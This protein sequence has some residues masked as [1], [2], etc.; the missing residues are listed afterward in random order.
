MTR[1]PV[2]YAVLNL[3]TEKNVNEFEYKRSWIRY[4]TSRQ[5]EEQ[6]RADKASDT[7][8]DGQTET[9]ARV[10]GPRLAVQ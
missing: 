7:Q 1:R 4:L 8:T 6:R 2:R 10:S 5:K 3:F 9:G